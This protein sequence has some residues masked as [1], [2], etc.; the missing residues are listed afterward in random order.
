MVISALERGIEPACFHVLLDL[1]IPLLGN[2]LLEPLREAGQLGT[3]KT[4]NE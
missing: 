3:R 1:A 2:E 4:G